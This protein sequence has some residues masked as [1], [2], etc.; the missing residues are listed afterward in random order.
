MIKSQTLLVMVDA[1][2]AHKLIVR[3][4]HHLDDVNNSE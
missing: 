3:I 2:K 1:V 4:F